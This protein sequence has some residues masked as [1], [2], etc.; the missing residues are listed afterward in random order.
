MKSNTSAVLPSSPSKTPKPAS[1]SSLVNVSS[2]SHSIGKAPI[3]EVKTAAEEVKT[4]AEEAKIKPSSSPV[5]SLN[6][7]LAAEIR[8]KERT[9]AL[10]DR[11]IEG[12]VGLKEQ[13][14]LRD[15]R[16]DELNAKMLGV[17]A[18]VK[19]KTRASLAKLKEQVNSLQSELHNSQLAYLK[20]TEAIAQL[21]A[22]SAEWKDKYEDEKESGELLSGALTEE[23]EGVKAELGQKKAQLLEMKKDIQQL[24]KIIQDL[25][26]LN[27]E[28]NG[29]IDS[30]NKDT[31]TMNSDY[32]T[33]IAKSEQ[34]EGLEKELNEYLGAN[35]RLEK[36]VNRLTDMLDRTNKAKQAIE[37]ASREAQSSLQQLGSLLIEL[38]SIS[39][40]DQRTSQVA[41]EVAEGLT[42]IRHKLKVVTPEETSRSQEADETQLQAELRELRGMLKEKDR[43]AARDQAEL[44]SLNFKLSRLEAQHE[45]E[46]AE[47]LETIERHHKKSSVFLEQVTSFTDRLDACRDELGKK[48]SKLQ[49]SQTQVLHLKDR[50]E[51]MRVKVKEHMERSSNLEKVMKE[52]R[53]SII[54]TKTE[55]FDEQK[56]IALKERQMAKAMANVEA[57]N[58]IVFQKDTDVIRKAKEVA[59]LTLQVTELDSR[60]KATQAKSKSAGFEGVEEFAKKLDEKNREVEILKEM[61]RGAQAEVKQKDGLISRFR[62]R[63]E[64]LL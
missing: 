50:I 52:Q 48:E 40:G 62:K 15:K 38:R 46:K 17:E 51:E 55:R 2:R 10:L 64:E 47:L 61:I 41:G 5:Q 59:A 53:A 1:K 39:S 4:A 60:L 3:E 49:M 31:A 9:L 23:I 63:P 45:K 33:A 30:I 44:G 25:T 14:L 6:E 54:K 24:S 11:N 19:V 26:K 18:K 27:A 35:Q 58:E 20:S 56:K 28:L 7:A 21:R 36:Q 37:G 32:F 16:I 29:K 13:L 34:V 8:S 57:M 43:K 42:S 22:E 12:D